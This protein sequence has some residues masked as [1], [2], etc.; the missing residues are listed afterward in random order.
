[1]RNS[2]SEES[3]ERFPFQF[4]DSGLQ[5]PSRSEAGFRVVNL[6]DAARAAIGKNFQLGAWI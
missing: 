2:P 3:D 6:P 4:S 5:K 1:M